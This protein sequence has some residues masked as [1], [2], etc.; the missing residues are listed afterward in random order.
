MK[1]WVGEPNYVLA[2][3]CPTCEGSGTQPEYHDFGYTERLSCPDCQGS[4]DII[5]TSLLNDLGLKAVV[6]AAMSSMTQ[7]EVTQ[8]RGGF[9][10]TDQH[11]FTQWISEWSKEDTDGD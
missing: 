11:E 9:T 8:I 7:I 4:G 3:R 2:R 1:A 10:D 5:P 6:D